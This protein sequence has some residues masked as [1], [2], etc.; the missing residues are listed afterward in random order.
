MYDVFLI[1]DKSLYEEDYKRLKQSIPT[2]KCV[3]TIEQAQQSCVTKFLWVVYP[4][5]EIDTNFYFD[6]VPDDW[7]H[8][9]VHLFLNDNEFDGLREVELPP[10]IRTL[11]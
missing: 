2:V 1:A 11:T 9:Y 4:D 10:E 3:K 8:D 7:S 6:Y 5:L